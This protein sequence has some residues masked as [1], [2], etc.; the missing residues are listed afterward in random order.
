[1][2]RMDE[3]SQTRTNPPEARILPET[4]ART[5]AERLRLLRAARLYV[6]TD[7]RTSR[8]DLESFLHAVYD[9]GADIVQLRDKSLSAAAE[10]EA[11][12]L[13]GRVAREHGALFAANDRADLALLCGADVFHG[14]QEDISPAEARAVLGPDVLIGRSTRTLPQAEAALVDPDVDYFCAGPVWETPT[15][16]G[17]PAVGLGHVEAV[18]ALAEEAGR[19]GDAAGAAGQA[20]AV[21]HSAGDTDGLP[22]KPWFAIGGIDLG[23]LPEVVQA[24]ASRAVV[25]RAVTE[26]VD[27]AEAAA[28][29][30]QLLG[31]GD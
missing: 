21:V 25:V 3:L 6:C 15:K 27:P 9:G 13:L 5:R 10:L 16:P 22:Y 20:G 1:M 4:P 19:T 28:A 26:A 11:L 31:S 17:R 8:G 23:R 18:A 24:G 2:Q 12:T 30:R 14:G 29:L 7:A